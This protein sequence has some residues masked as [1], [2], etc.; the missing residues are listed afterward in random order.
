MTRTLAVLAGIWFFASLLMLGAA[1]LAVSGGPFAIVVLTTLFSGLT[2]LVASVWLFDR[3]L[4]VPIRRLADHVRLE[5]D[6]TSTSRQVPPDL[7]SRSDA[8]GLLARQL[9]KLIEESRSYNAALLEQ[10]LNDPL[11]GLGNRRLLE[12]RL[13]ML[14]PLSRRLSCTVSAMMIDVDH[15]KAFNDHYGHPAGDACLVDIAGVLRD[16]FRRETDVVVRLGGEEF[17]VLLIHTGKEEAWALADAMRGMIQALGLPHEYSPV[18]EVVT[19][20]VGV[21]TSPNGLLIDIDDMIAHADQALYDCKAHGRNQVAA[22]VIG[23]E[24]TAQAF[25]PSTESTA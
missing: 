17:L 25:R 24:Q 12:S 20:S 14:V 21:V 13:N 4:L 19:V 7:T 2:G 9:Q 22:R 6:F 3:R 8:V 10:T 11:T 15:F 23:V 18:A 5:H 1:W 16:T